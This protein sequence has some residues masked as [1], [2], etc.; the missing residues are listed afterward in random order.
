MRAVIQ[1]AREA[2]VTVDGT[3]VGAIDRGFVILLG[4]GHD[5]TSEKAAALARRIAALRILPD[6]NGVMNLSLIDT[7]YSALVVSQFT[8]MADTRKGNRP[9]YM[10]AAPPDVAERLYEEFAQRLRELIGA[11]KVATG[12]FRA[13]MDVAFVNEGPVTILVD[14]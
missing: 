9:S 8:L 12:V 11:D 3:V 2:S 4:V 10:G 6:S 13:R 7:G 1:R 14:S 5:D